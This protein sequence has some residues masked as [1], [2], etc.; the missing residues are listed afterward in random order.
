M[1][2]KY[3][4][5]KSHHD[6]FPFKKR[7]F[8][9]FEN[10]MDEISKINPSTFNEYRLNNLF[11]DLRN[12]ICSLIDQIYQEVKVMLKHEVKITPSSRRR[13]FRVQDEKRSPKRC[14]V[15]G[16]NRTMNLCHVIPRE[17]G[18]ADSDENLIPLSP[19]HHYLFDEGRLSKVEFDKIDLKDKAPDTIEY[20]QRIHEKKHEMFWR[21][22]TSSFA[23]CNCGSLD[24]DY[25]VTE[26]G[27]VVEPCLT[28]NKC[29]EKWSLASDHPVQQMSVTAYGI[30]EE[31][32]DAEKR[33]RVLQAVRK[34]NKSIKEYLMML[35]E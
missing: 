16:E 31:I 5:G 8:E 23:G 28:C 27:N 32:S 33:K 14:Q 3:I 18:G 15:C 12:E 35:Q 4:Y 11:V 17:E 19:N 10:R 6:K 24:F 2:K 22:G 13:T 1:V 30:Y 26:S 20:F 21:Y 29:G 9:C 25:G 7:V 34:L